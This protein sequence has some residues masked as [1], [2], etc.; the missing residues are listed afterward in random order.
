MKTKCQNLFSGKNQ[1]NIIH[2]PSAECAQGMVMVKN[3]WYGNTFVFQTMQQQTYGVGSP[4]DVRKK[5]VLMGTV[6]AVIVVIF[7][8]IMFTVIF[9]LDTNDVCL[10]LCML[11]NFACFF[12][13]CGFFFFSNNFFKNIF[14]EYYQSNIKFGSRSGRTFCR[15]LSVSKLF[16]KVISR[17]KLFAKVISRWQKS[18][19]AGKELKRGSGGGG[20][21]VGV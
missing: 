2:L 5:K 9:W 13:V 12:V 17:R 6:T 14:Q 3:L 16:A 11:G 10:T 7:F 19:L 4:E 21:W 1:K 15:A 8:I 20:L 18:P